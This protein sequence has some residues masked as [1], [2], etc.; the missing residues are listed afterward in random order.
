MHVNTTHQMKESITIFVKR[1]D[2]SSIYTKYPH[3]QTQF[4]SE[5]CR[6][7]SVDY[8]GNT[9][10][11]IIVVSVIPNSVLRFASPSARGI[12]IF[13]ARHT[14][15]KRRK[16]RKKK[17]STLIKVKRKQNGIA[18]IETRIGNLRVTLCLST[19]YS[20]NFS[21]WNVLMPKH[22]L[23]YFLL[24]RFPVPSSDV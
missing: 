5:K 16:E 1:N 15:T 14:N 23:K 22:F 2:S 7:T 18:D 6:Q 4:Q 11:T 3:L 8:T 24:G 21:F 17:I 10:H 12:V 9:Q 19:L 13:S 20:N